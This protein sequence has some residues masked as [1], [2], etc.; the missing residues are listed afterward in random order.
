MMNQGD[1]ADM[2]SDDEEKAEAS[3]A[4][5]DAAA[6]GAAVSSG[7]EPSTSGDMPLFLAS[8]ASPAQAVTCP[9]SLPRH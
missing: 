4:A 9:S 2:G 6:R 8:A 3:T 5:G 7:G 1:L